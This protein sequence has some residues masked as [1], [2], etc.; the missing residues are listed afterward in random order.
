MDL[1]P[2]AQCVGGGSAPWGAELLQP[3]LRAVAAALRV[4]PAAA[5]PFLS[6]ASTAVA[7]SPCSEAVSGCSWKAAGCTSAA[8]LLGRL[9]VQDG[10][11]V[12][13]CTSDGAC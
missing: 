6:M 3:L 5:G 8:S 10:L 7:A 2:L 9:H 1:G 4:T 12:Q 11:A 13:C